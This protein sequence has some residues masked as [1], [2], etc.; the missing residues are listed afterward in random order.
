MINYFSRVCDDV[1]V[2]LLGPVVRLFVDMWRVWGSKPASGLRS[3][4]RISERD[5]PGRGS[6]R[7]AVRAAAVSGRSLPAAVWVQRRVEPWAYLSPEA[8]FMRK[9]LGVKF[10]SEGISPNFDQKFCLVL[11]FKRKFRSAWEEFTLNLDS[12]NWPKN[13]K[14][15]SLSY[16]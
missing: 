6:E 1:T 10:C 15:R 16:V 13:V 4:I 11:K 2:E 12:W 3:L 8:N 14:C 7:P 9:K 5:V